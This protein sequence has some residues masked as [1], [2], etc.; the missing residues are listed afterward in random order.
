MYL[1]K[2]SALRRAGIVA[3]AFFCLGAVW[4][5]SLENASAAKRS[6]SFCTGYIAPKTW[7]K[8]SNSHYWGVAR[9]KSNNAYPKCVMAFWPN[10]QPIPLTKICNNAVEQWNCFF[11][12]CE[13]PSAYQR[14]RKI[15]AGVYNGSNSRRWIEGTIWWDDR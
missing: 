15:R 1:T 14:S 2:A 13:S 9:A 8:T 12:A 5:A 4:G 11:G 10:G 7:C 3:L 6:S